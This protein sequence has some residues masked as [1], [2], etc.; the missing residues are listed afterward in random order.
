MQPWRRRRVRRRRRRPGRRRGRR[1]RRVGRPGRRAHTG[2]ALL[3]GALRS[4][5]DGVPCFDDNGD[6]E[7]T[8]T[9][10]APWLLAAFG[11]F[12]IFL[13]LPLPA[14]AAGIDMPAGAL[15]LS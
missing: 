5:F 11:A 10:L 9:R 4:L 13:A 7:M 8:R 14:P 2:G 15:V 12:L 6:I 3:T 1:R